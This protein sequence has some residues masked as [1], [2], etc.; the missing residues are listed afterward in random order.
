LQ[1]AY[2]GILADARSVAGVDCKCGALLGC[3]VP[4]YQ[5]LLS[6][7]AVAQDERESLGRQ[8]NDLSAEV[9]ALRRKLE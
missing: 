9:R 3:T 6:P 8:I 2:G 5:R 7:E 4:Q 1:L